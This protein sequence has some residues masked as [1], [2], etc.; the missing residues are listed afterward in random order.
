MII[1]T[2]GHIDH[3]K[4]A[5]VEALTG[6]RMD[7]L[8]EE[9]A[10]GITIDLNFAPLRL[11]DGTL[12]GMVDVPGHEDFVRTMVAGAAGVDLVLLV[13]AADEGIMPQTREHLAIVEALGIPRGI[14]VLTKSDLV[15]PPRL[16]VLG[17][18]VDAWLSASPVAFSAAGA[19]S[20]RSG[21]G[22]DALRDDIGAVAA[23]APA[24]SDRAPFRMPVDRAFS[25]AGTGTVVTGSVWSG[26]LEVGAEVR[27][28]PSDRVARVR[29]IEVHG[30]RC[31]RARAGQ[32][33]ALGL[34]GLDREAVRRGDT[35][36]DR[37]LPWEVTTALDVS[38]RLLANAP[39]GLAARTRVHV[40]LGTAEVL[41]RVQ[42]P[43]PIAPG[44]AGLARLL[45][46][47]PVVAQGGD[48]LVIRSYSPV[49]TI[50]GGM[51]LDPHPPG[52]P[53]V[54]PAGLESLDAHRRLR[55]L[56][57]RH[58]AGRSSEE[59]AL[60]SGLAI[61]EVEASLGGDSGFRR[62]PRGWA[63]A[64]DLKAAGDR[65][66]ALVAAFHGEHPSS[67]GMPIETLRREVHR[68]ALIAE[69]AIADLAA[70]GT[71]VMEAGVARS[72]GFTP[73]IVGGSKVVDRVLEVI[74]AAGLA[75]PAVPELER[76][77]PGT[78]VAGALR[79]VAR[80]GQV[81]AVSRDWYVARG[82]LEGF[83]GMLAEVGRDGEITVG[84][85]KD[86]TGLSRKYLIPLLE[87][88]DRRGL[89]RRIGES[90]RLT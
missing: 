73:Q 8:A 55:A 85:M 11:A 79:L 6:R 54:W 10:R 58:P 24:R 44:D 82:A 77:L 71:L 27:L 69:A 87:W 88:A 28:L 52:G 13:I 50:G 70:A 36:V 31:E 43:S 65:G 38:V 21:A 89:T 90:R 81:E 37:Q 16:A 78:D 32:R 33:A 61:P 14:P 22:V 47:A 18:E 63:R 53:A 26:S 80:A 15:D 25:V 34:A 75:A 2:A 59:L 45:C 68:S 35:V 5:L 67:A 39:R 74:R 60:L 41:A 66:L 20:A 12:A 40:H 62:L 9:Q 84:K 64:A 46:E 3:G 49:E 72:P 29:T 7:R 83:G 4:S 48:R 19:V 17:N 57:E 1:G 23:R 30:A 51:V 56:V 76:Q 86:R 42:P